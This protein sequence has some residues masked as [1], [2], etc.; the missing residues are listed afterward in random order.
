VIRDYGQADVIL[1]GVSRSGKTPTCIYLALHYGLRAANYP[2]VEEDLVAPVLPA[3]LKTHRSRLIGLTIDPEQLQRIRSRRRNR[4]RYADPEQCRWEVN[5]AEALFRRHHLPVID[6]TS[7]SIEEVAARITT[8]IL[9]ALNR[10]AFQP[11]AR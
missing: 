9:P 6:T 8:G 7:V 3:P 10:T 5:Q 11:S 1:V 2:L 4:G